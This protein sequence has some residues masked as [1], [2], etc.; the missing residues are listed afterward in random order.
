VAVSGTVTLEAAFYGVPMVIVY[1]VSRLAYDLA[2]GGF[3]K[4]ESVGFIPV[5]DY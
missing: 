1:R 3:I 2:R 5:T 4:S